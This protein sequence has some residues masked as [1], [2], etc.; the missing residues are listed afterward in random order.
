MNDVRELCRNWLAEQDA[1]AERNKEITRLKKEIKDA[2]KKLE[3]QKS[4]WK[5]NERTL[6]EIVKKIYEQLSDEEKALVDDLEY[7]DLPSRQLAK[8]V[9]EADKRE[10]N[11]I[12]A[13]FVHIEGA[14]YF[15]ETLIQTMT[16]ELEELKNASNNN[17]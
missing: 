9:L 6:D 4:I 3:G 15:G 11:H 13:R 2:K 1:K 7:L 14:I 17:N 8:S 16:E 10:Y 5:L 12:L